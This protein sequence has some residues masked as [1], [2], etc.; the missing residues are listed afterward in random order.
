[1]AEVDGRLVGALS[2]DRPEAND[3][4]TPFTDM[5]PIGYLRMA[6]RADDRGA[7]RRTDGRGAPR[8]RW[9]GHAC[10]LHYALLNP[11]SGP[12]WHRMGYR[13]LWTGWKASPAAALR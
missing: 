10:T 11:R 9:G 5:H 4:L 7:G 1:L 8:V 3:W 2:A 12:F 13:P 6:G